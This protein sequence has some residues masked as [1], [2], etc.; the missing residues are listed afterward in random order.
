MVLRKKSCVCLQ[1]KKHS[2]QHKIQSQLG[3]GNGTSRTRWPSQSQIRQKHHCKSN[4][5]NSQN[6]ALSKQK[7]LSQP[8]FIL[9]ST[10]IFAFQSSKYKAPLKITDE[11]AK[12][13]KGALL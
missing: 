8:A 13:F 11:R 6:Y 7:Y 9:K 2:K 4:G 12:C 1:S 10:N 3:K 5:S